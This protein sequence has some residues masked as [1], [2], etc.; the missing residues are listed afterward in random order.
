[1]P[2]VLLPTLPSILV[3]RNTPFIH[4]DLSWLQFNERVLSQARSTNNPPLEKLKFLG[5]TASNLD[6]FFMIRFSSL[7]RSI[8]QARRTKNGMEN[9]LLRIRTNLLEAVHKFTV[10]QSE[11]LDILAK[12]LEPLGV[13]VARKLKPETSAY[14]FGRHIFVEQ[15]LPQLSAPAAYSTSQI[16]SLDNLQSAL[17]LGDKLWIPIP[18]S[19]PPA[20]SAQESKT[21]NHFIYF[22]DD[23]LTQFVGNSFQYEGPRGLVRL[24]RDGDLRIDI[25]EEDS[26]SIPDIVRGGLGVRD[27]GRPIRIQY[28]GA[29]P[30]ALPQQASHIFRLSPAQIIPAPS[31]LHL[32]GLWSVISNI[33]NEVRE[34]SKLLFPA[35][36]PFIPKSCKG[37]ERVFDVL[38]ERDVLLH[39][40]YDSFDAYVQWI[41]T[42]CKDP[43]V[44]MI[45]QTVYRV[46]ALSPVIDALKKAA[47]KKRI[48]VVIE[49]R[50]RFDELN[51]LRLAEELRQAGVE[52]T[53]GFGKLKLHAKVALI[54]R[55]EGGELKRYTHLSTGNYNAQTARQYTDLSII[56]AHTEIGEDA[57]HFFESIAQ[58]LIPEKFKQIVSAPSRLHRKLTSLIEAE[59]Q[60]ALAG[61][62]ARIVAKMNALVDEA[63]IQKLYDASQ[64][65]VQVDLI[66]RGACSLIPGVK[67]L[68]E[69]IRVISIVDRFL[70]HSRLYYFGASNIIFLSSADWMPRN[71]FSRLEIAFPVLDQRIF[72]FLSETIIPSYLSDRLK[73]R[74]LT[75]QGVWR[76]RALSQIKADARQVLE[77]SGLQKEFSAQRYFTELSQLRYAGTALDT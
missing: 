33:S 41:Q 6:E 40:P 59:I 43:K 7:N 72:K 36:H 69:N 20:Y 19:L 73:A 44:E 58:D 56:T 51:N 45:E 46:D 65:G 42:A 70:E 67:K 25:E 68:S 30:A 24:T 3:A 21:K 66:V 64:A 61:N 28:R 38:K 74:E 17:I 76:K 1:M 50:A 53:F 9:H 8:A 39:H 14:D 37:G 26:E 23:L 31:T 63:I 32:H 71:F 57:E 15:I 13:F 18:R 47:K 16:S 4:R 10:K 54:R 60:A 11:T 34:P 48:R 62:K 22:L 52:V 2:P 5:I 77:S 35:P 27:R 49:L 55:R 75:P 12:E 29:T